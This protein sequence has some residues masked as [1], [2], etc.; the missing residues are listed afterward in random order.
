[1]TSASS[2]RS[3]GIIQCMLD[4]RLIFTV[5]AV[6]RM[7]MRRIGYNDVR[8]AIKTGR[9]IEEYP[10]DTPYPSRLVL[11]WVGKQPIH[12]VVADNLEDNESIVV[13]V[14]EPDLFTWEPDFERRLGQ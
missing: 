11:G 8:H 12:I 5:H 2:G 13:T 3:F 6:R 14:Y 9:T 4:K 10:D 7:F 1:M